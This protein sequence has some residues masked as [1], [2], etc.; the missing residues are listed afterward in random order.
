MG[1]HTEKLVMT[2]STEQSPSQIRENLLRTSGYFAAFVLLGMMAASLG[3]TLPGLADHTQTRLTE[4]GILFTARS[5]GFLLGAILGGR[6]FD[7]I[8]GNPLMGAML[9]LMAVSMALAPTLSLLWALIVALMVVGFAEGVMD[10]GG[11]TLLV[12]TYRHRV[13]PYMNGLH[14]FFGVGAFLSPLV[15]GQTILISGDIHWAYWGIAILMMPVAFWLTRLPN[16]PIRNNFDARVASRSNPG[17]IA[18]VAALL[19]LYVGAEVSFGGW[20]FTYALSIGVRDPASAALLTSV[21]WGSF[22]VG[23]LLAVPLSVRFSPG[24]ILVFS[25]IGCQVSLAAMLIWPESLSVLWMTTFGLGIS[26]A[27]IFPN[28][29]SLAA[30]RFGISGK[31]TGWIFVGASLG[32]MFLPWYLGRLFE[33][34]GSQVVPWGILLDLAAAL[35]V[36]GIIFLISS[37]QE[38]KT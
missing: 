34:R 3:P 10:V 7:R 14:F 23:R 20:I 22:T 1:E 26:M 36:L 35:L 18:L 4:I 9:A 24:R 16:P 27:S 15:I 29:V 19:F 8:S 13:G 6:W 25:L 32:G 5:F 11:N 37:R 38:F 12:W 17:M 31:V 30:R 2:L 21:F 28:V 33:S